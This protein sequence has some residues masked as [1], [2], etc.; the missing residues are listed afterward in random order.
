MRPIP[1]NLR[2]GGSMDGAVDVCVNEVER[3]DRQI[4]SVESVRRE[5]DGWRVDG[6]I[7]GGRDYSCI[8]DRGGQVR[9]VTVD[10]RAI[11]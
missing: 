2:S 8:I 1:E 4:E 5:A 11:I 10:G 9:R 6:G 7:T 3:G